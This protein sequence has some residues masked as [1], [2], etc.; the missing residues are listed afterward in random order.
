MTTKQ[1]PIHE[2][3]LGD[4]T[5]TFVREISLRYHG[6]KH[7]DTVNPIRSPADAADFVRRIL[8]DNVREHF[9][10]LFLDGQHQVAGFYVVATGTASSCPIAARE[11][12]Q[13]AILAGAIALV[14]AHNHPSGSVNPSIEDRAVTKRL[15]DAGNLIGIP[16]L[17]HIIVGAD[18]F[19]SFKEG[20]ELPTA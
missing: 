9:V 1:K 10:A 13:G 18:G 3:K 17:D 20:G 15:F 6:P 8:P 14:V 11:V 12:F 5:T 7:R 19:Y 2:I 16:L 4:S